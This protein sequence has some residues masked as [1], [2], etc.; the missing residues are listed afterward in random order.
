MWSFCACTCFFLSR[1]VCLIAFFSHLLKQKVHFPQTFVIILSVSQGI[2]FHS[3][4]RSTFV[5]CTLL[6][7]HITSLFMINNTRNSTFVIAL[8][9]ITAAF[10]HTGQGKICA[11]S[12]MPSIRPTSQWHN[13]KFIAL[14]WRSP[15]TR[16]LDIEIF[17]NRNSDC[18]QEWKNINNVQKY[19]FDRVYLEVIK[20]G[21]KM[22]WREILDE[23][24]D[25]HRNL[26][27]E[28]F[29]V[30]IYLFE[31]SMSCEFSNVWSWE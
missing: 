5:L 11:E 17:W 22:R 7:V 25:L 28:A 8:V 14:I 18:L 2:V 15:W 27:G 23:E 24:V 12:R 3:C 9:L 30:F 29:E 21:L 26:E 6:K 1:I 31:Q 20:N 16:V 19:F 13:H 4:Q 10:S